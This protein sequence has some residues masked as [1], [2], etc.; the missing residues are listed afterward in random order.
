MIAERDRIVRQFANHI[1]G[2]IRHAITECNYH[3]AE[4]IRMKERHGVVEA[5]RRV[6]MDHPVTRPPSGFMRMCEEGHLEW[7]AEA[8]VLQ[9][10]SCMLFDRAALERARERLLAFQYAG[11]VSC[12]CLDLPV[13]NG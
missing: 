12:E 9:H 8:A 3:P 2:L 1:E 11:N 4:F 7:T 5:C 10:P 6:I 13:A